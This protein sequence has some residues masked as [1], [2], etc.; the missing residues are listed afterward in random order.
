MGIVQVSAT[1]AANEAAAAFFN[2]L[3]QGA[4]VALRFSC[5]AEV[6]YI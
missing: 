1:Q 3:M 4:E 5:M 2:I 6:F